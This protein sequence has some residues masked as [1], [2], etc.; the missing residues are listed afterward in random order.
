MTREEARTPDVFLQTRPT[1]CG[2]ACVMMALHAKGVGV[3]LTRGTEGKIFRSLKMRGPGVEE[4]NV[5]PGI[6]LATFARRKGCTVRAVVEN[7]RTNMWDLWRTTDPALYA[8]Q[9]KAYEEARHAGVDISYGTVTASAIRSSLRAG[10]LIIVGVDLG[11][12][13][14][15]VL[16]YGIDGNNFLLVDPLYGKTRMS[17]GTLLRQMKMPTGKWFIEIQ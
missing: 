15:A 9:Q 13:K 16:V 4:R 17:S 10:N 6:A 5:V 7:G 3:S 8:V 11:D 2:V 14:H 12:V 1:T